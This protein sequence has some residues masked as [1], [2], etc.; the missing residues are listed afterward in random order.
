[1]LGAAVAVVIGPGPTRADDG[2]EGITRFVAGLPTE[3]EEC[4]FLRQLCVGAAASR[5]REAETPPSADVLASRQGGIAAARLRDAATAARA[6][7]RKRGRRLAC[8][9]DGPCRRVLPRPGT[10]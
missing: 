9:E 7:E 1:M 3:T 8:F 5:D 2:S 6:I 10:P 4:T